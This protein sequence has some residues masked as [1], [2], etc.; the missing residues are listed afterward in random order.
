MN[1]RVWSTASP[2]ISSSACSWRALQEGDTGEQAV[3]LLEADG[4]RR[5]AVTADFQPEGCGRGGEAQL[6]VALQ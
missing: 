5:V 3:A 1:E 6:C 2:S 4:E